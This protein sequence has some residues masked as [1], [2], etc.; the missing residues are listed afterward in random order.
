MDKKPVYWI[1]CSGGVD[2]VVLCRLLHEQAIPFGVLH[3]NFQLREG[4]SD[5]DEEFVKELAATLEAPIRVEK[6]DT[7]NYALKNGLNTQ[8]AARE[9]RYN[10]FDEVIAKENATVLIAQHFDDQLETF[11]LQLRRGGGVKGLSGMPFYKKGYLRPLLK[12]T[13]E[14]ILLLANKKGWSWREDRT[15][16]LNDYKRNWYRNE[17]LD[18]LASQG[19]PLAEVVPLMNDFQKL[20]RFLNTLPI[21]EEIAIAD[22]LTYPIWYRQM[23]IDE[24]DLGVYSENEITKLAQAKKGRFIGTEEVKVWNEGSTLV[25]VR[26]ELDVPEKYLHQEVI[27][28]TTLELNGTDL[29]LDASKTQG[30]LSFRK[31]RAGDKFKPLGMNGEKALGKFLRDR[32]VPAHQKEDVM[33]L[34]NRNNVILGVFGFGVDDRYK[35]DSLTQEVLVVSLRIK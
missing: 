35:I 24:H 19:F 16:A 11:F 26:K 5:R 29:F 17:V 22:W 6:F 15:N 28:I 25:F 10:W 34:A 23:I 33:V 7:E 21:P 1:A 27:S 30:G 14:E 4:D 13:K 20:L 32:K 18:F 31:W 12:Y 8:L 9:L 2:S 3:C